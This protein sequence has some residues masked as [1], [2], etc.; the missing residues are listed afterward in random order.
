MSNQYWEEMSKGQPLLGMKERC[1]DCA[2]STG[3]YTEIA[4]ELLKQ[5]LEIQQ[6]CVQAW[7]CHNFANRACKGAEEYIL[8]GIC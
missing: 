3:F 4:D 6:K 1:H 5:P 8:Q 7:Y 2:I